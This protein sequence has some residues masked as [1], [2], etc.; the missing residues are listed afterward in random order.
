MKDSY[1]KL[2]IFAYSIIKHR[3]VKLK[4]HECKKERERQRERWEKQKSVSED[5]PFLERNK[6]ISEKKIVK[7]TFASDKLI[8]LFAYCIIKP[9]SVQLK[10]HKCKKERKRKREKKREKERERKTGEKGER[11]ES[12]RERRREKLREKPFFAKGKAKKRWGFSFLF[13]P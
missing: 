9:R 5:Q 10:K 13:L 11:K 7:M 8:I 4:K 6:G 2:I 3:S 1:L 12:K